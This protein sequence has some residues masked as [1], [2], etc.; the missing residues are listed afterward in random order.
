MNKITTLLLAAGLTGSLTACMAT[1]STTSDSAS[2]TADNRAPAATVKPQ[3]EK[4]GN[5]GTTITLE[6][7]M[8]DPAWLGRQPE[9]AGW[10][11]DGSAVVYE[12]ERENSELH[13]VFYRGSGGEAEPQKVAMA[14]LH[15]YR[16]DE[17][18]VS[19]DGRYTA[20]RYQ[21]SVFVIFPDSEIVQLTRGG[22]S[23]ENLRFM[24]DNRLMAQSGNRIVA[25]DLTTG[26]REQLLSW[27]FAE[28]PEA[29]SEPKDFIA[30]E[31]ITLIE[32]IAK[33]RRDRQARADEQDALAA[34]NI[35]VAPD[36]FYFSE[37]HRLVSAS[38]SPN[39]RSAIIVTTEDTP[40][41][42]DS[43]VMPHYIQE[44]GR[45]DNKEVR[46]RV[47]DAKPQ[48]DTV[49]LVDL[50]SQ[51][52]TELSYVQLPGYNEDVLAEVKAENARA[53][54]ETYQVNRLPRAIGLLDSWY[55]S[56]PAVRWHNNGEQVAL[57]LEAWDNKDRWIATVDFDS[58][59]LVSQH[60]LH[61]DA[62]VNYRFNQ[63]GWLNNSETL[64]YQS[65]H[66]GYAHMY[67]Q[68]PGQAPRALTSGQF[69]T[70]NPTLT[71]DDQW[72]YYTANKKH[73]GVYEVYR[74]NIATGD[75]QALTDLNGMTNYILSPDESSLLLT[76]SK[77]TQPPELF[78][79][80][81]TPEAGATQLTDTLS[82]RF[83]ELPWAVPQVVA[84]PSSDT[85]QPIYARV[86]LPEDYE[87]GEPRRA[88]VFNHGAGYL[89]NA[90]LGWSGYFREF[91][92]HSMLVQQGYVVLD[93]DFRASAGYGRDWRT[94]I[95]RQMGTPEVQDLRDGV[96]WLVDNA[97]VDRERI[98]TYGG[99]YGGFL[100]FMALFNDP[101]L[102]QAGAALRPV[103]DWAHY[104]W[105]YTSNILNT[106]DVDPIAYRRSSPIYHAEGLESALL[107]NAPMVDDNVF[108]VDSVRL[109]QRLI[110]LEKE[111][112]ETAIY[113][114]EPHGFVQPS[115]WLDE[116]RR[117]YKLFETNL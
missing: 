100:T 63:F 48:S 111:N 4:T 109:V 3:V 117:I 11:V 110:E 23:L 37:D 112:F 32:Y 25:I 68:K 80:A 51:T 99:S 42:D 78:L 16:F 102:F 28:E 29:V 26:R 44:D 69:I 76:H 52:K 49:W 74:V 98:G 62:W 106:P 31:Q 70:D 85:S 79:Q 95:Y 88:V 81:A 90:H 83:K 30:S 105:G 55:W 10:S 60:R 65:E 96:D 20:F 33:R 43:D 116:Y 12:R 27:A 113:P 82:E 19:N 101:D 86:Y 45:I 114:V 38:V 21:D 115:S 18:V 72:L 75:S 39:G 8:A 67:V 34:A 35:A 71:R 7:I 40:W 1:S 94:A 77:V 107:I 9:N 46:R 47:A 36:T 2:Q 73:P 91:M 89:Q 58:Q 66:T 84:I 104:N 22:A 50:S 6:Q 93:M 92:F 59:T 14:D 57:M 24:T 53:R 103:T 108:F 87:A 41:R 54:G 56:E 17:R 97:N 15:K 64:F 61:D 13:D 5:T